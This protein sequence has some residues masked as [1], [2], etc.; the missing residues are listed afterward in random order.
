[1]CSSDLIRAFSDEEFKKQDGS[2][3]VVW[4]NPQSYQRSLTIIKKD[5]QSINAKGSSPTHAKVGEE[6]FTFKLIFDTTGLVLSPLG[7]S[8]MPAE[9]VVSLIEPLIEKIAK[10]P[11]N[12]SQPN[13]VQL[14]WAQLQARCVLTSMSI[15]YKLF[16]PD[17]TPIRAEA[18]LSFLAFTSAASLSRQCD[19]E[20]KDTPKFVTVVEGDTLPALCQ[21]IYGDSKYYLDV[22]QLNDL[23]CFRILKAG[24]QLNFPPLADL[25][26][27]DGRVS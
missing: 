22:A 23:F 15:D 18:T 17:G 8:R 26:M 20:P 27:N 7:S 14:S 24:T 25:R 3:F 9:G 2:D 16:R 13:F 19:V 11:P 10:V 21:R 4:M 12:R 1:M 6:T 5:T